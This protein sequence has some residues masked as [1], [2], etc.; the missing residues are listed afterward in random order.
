LLCGQA[1][2][3]G[4]QTTHFSFAPRTSIVPRAF[5]SCSPDRHCPRRTNSAFLPALRTG[6]VPRAFLSCSPDKHWFPAHK[7]ST[8]RG[9]YGSRAVLCIILSGTKSIRLWML[10][11]PLLKPA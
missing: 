10:C 7:Q 8:R 2:S 4:T 5:L 3:P 1:W 6:I 9:V 11:F